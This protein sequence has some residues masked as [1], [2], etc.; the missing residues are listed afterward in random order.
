MGS[1][2]L[3]D[4]GYEVL[5]AGIQSPEIDIQQPGVVHRVGSLILMPAGVRDGECRQA[6][7]TLGTCHGGDQR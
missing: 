3:L 1:R 5:L 2:D 4:R 6:G 7:S